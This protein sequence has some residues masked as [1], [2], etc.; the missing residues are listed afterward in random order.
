MLSNSCEM[1]SSVGVEGTQYLT[2][3][4]QYP[5]G[6]DPLDVA[7]TEEVPLRYNVPA[8]KEE[9]SPSFSDGSRS[10]RVCVHYKGISKYVYFGIIT[11]EITILK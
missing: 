9:G 1:L 6:W 2:L 5:P 8:L 7:F 10:S 11:P 4:S 3:C